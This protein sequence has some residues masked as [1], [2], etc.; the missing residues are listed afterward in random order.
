MVHERQFSWEI[1]PTKTEQMPLWKKW[2][3]YMQH[4][5]A[6]ARRIFYLYPDPSLVSFSEVILV[7]WKLLVFLVHRFFFL[8]F[9]C[10]DDPVE[11]ICPKAKYQGWKF[12]LNLFRVSRFLIGWLVWNSNTYSKW[13]KCVQ[14]RFATRTWEK[15]EDITFAVDAVWSLSLIIGMYNYLRPIEKFFSLCSFCETLK[16]IDF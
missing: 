9:S 8:F 6:I 11:A 10:K 3:T 13:Q 4:K 12:S 5:L 16:N 2:D 1:H 14:L 7:S 15:N